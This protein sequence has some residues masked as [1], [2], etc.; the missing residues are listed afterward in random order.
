V[1][2]RCGYGFVL[3]KC[4]LVRPIKINGR[5]LSGQL[6]AQAGEAIPGP[7]P[8]YG[9]GAGGMPHASLGRAAGGFA[10]PSCLTEARVT[11]ACWRAHELGLRAECTLTIEN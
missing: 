1:R 3:A 4:A 6:S 5:A 8:G 9:L 2:G 10:G 7:G 11:M